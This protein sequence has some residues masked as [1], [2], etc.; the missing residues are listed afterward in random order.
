MK[1]VV[2]GACGLLGSTLVAEALARGDNVVALDNLMYS[3]HPPL[4]DLAGHP[5]LHFVR[6]DVRDGSAVERILREATPDA[7]V[8]LA[9]IVGAPA[10]HR[11]PELAAAV[12][13]HGTSNVVRALSRA[14]PEAHLIF[15]STDSTYGQVSKDQSVTEET[16]LAPLSEYGRDKE[17]GERLVRG[18]C[19]RWSILRFAT[20]FG[21]SRRL[22]L[23]LMVNDFTWQAVHN[24]HLIVYEA[25]FGRTFLHVKDIVRAIL[26]VLA[27]PDHTV[28]QAFNVGDDTLNVTKA[29]I[30]K[31]VA[32]VVPGTTLNLLGEGSDPDQRNY[33]V[34][35]TR[36]RALDFQATV[37]LRAGIEELVRGYA[38]IDARS[39]WRNA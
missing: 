16:P 28:A 17:A 38:M 10:C 21:L 29:E 24:R 8:H 30:A 39:S 6:A 27:H 22:R 9:A 34:D 2:T 4:L 14:C 5:N 7:V 26:L 25:G 31:V 11:D 15:A 13:V 36:I 1:I 12:N 18:G 19:R 23:D 20:A 3:G 37:S 33:I 32:E 35:H